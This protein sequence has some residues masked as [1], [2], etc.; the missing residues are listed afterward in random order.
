MLSAESSLLLWSLITRL[1]EAQILLPAAL[2]ASVWLWRRE[3]GRPLVTL[4]LPLLCL[5][6]LVTT[7]SK[8]AF[9]GWGVGIP[10]VNFT[11]ISGHS[12]FAAAVY[13]LLAG[14][15]AA[16]LSALG[17]RLSLLA[18]YALA[19]LVGVS[20]VK[21][22]AHSYSEVLAGLLLGGIASAL[23]LAL[24]HMP[25]A[26]VRWW[27]PV[28]LAVWLS[29]TPAGAPASRTHDWVTRLSLALSGREA[30]YTRTEM[31]NAWRLRK[32]VPKVT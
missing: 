26:K 3:T 10:A 18:A 16:P 28:G 4:W 17:Q 22:G 7:A 12:M 19:L 2:V 13:P 21:V 14:A 24:A 20:R 31:L 25:H 8:V 27:M 32:A 6:T 29:L 30:P 9:L 23:A 5:A 11:G 1:G 15:I